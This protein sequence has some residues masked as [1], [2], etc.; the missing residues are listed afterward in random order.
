MDSGTNSKANYSTPIA[1][2]LAGIIIA[3]AMYFSDGKKANAPADSQPAAANAGL[4][5]VRP[6][7][8]DDHIRGNPNAKVMIVEYSD[9]EC[10]FCGRFH[11]TMKQIMDDYGKTGQVAWV[12]RHY[13]LDQLH[14]KA[15][16]E[17]VALECAAELGG[18]DKFWAYTDR[19][20]AVTPANNG[21]DP[22]ELPKI[23]E[24]VGLDATAFNA[25]L[26]SGKFDAKIQADI[27]NAQ[28]TGGNGTPWSIIISQN[29]QKT[30][31]NGAYPY[32][33]VKQMVDALLAK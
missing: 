8:A 19:I 32:A 13:P 11:T 3:G 2:I 16:S 22:A 25:C 17:A 21:L 14:S 5:Q 7:S 26:I 29:G 33:S 23:A 1:I 27:D 20:Y 12:Y 10:P 24:Y 15:R 31:L 9:T 30:A 18:N 6:V 28:A 4:E